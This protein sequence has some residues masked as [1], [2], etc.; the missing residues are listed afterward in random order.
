MDGS[1]EGGVGWMDVGSMK[2]GQWV[3]RYIAPVG[4]GR[5]DEVGTYIAEQ[6]VGGD[7]EEDDKLDRK[8]DERVNSLRV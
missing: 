6:E 3:G 7:K 1:V 5:E 4:V 2:A 8:M